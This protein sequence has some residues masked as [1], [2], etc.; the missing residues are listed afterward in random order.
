VLLEEGQGV[1]EGERRAG[2]IARPEALVGEQDP[3]G[4][5]APVDQRLVPSR[6][7]GTRQVVALRSRARGLA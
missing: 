2:A 6:A 5:P 7:G 4:R 1:A 3:L